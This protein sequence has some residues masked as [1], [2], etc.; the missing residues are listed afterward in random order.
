M[1][2]RSLLLPGAL[3]LLAMALAVILTLGRCSDSSLAPASPDSHSGV[4][5][6][7]LQWRAGSSQRY[8]LVVESS[9]LMTM[10]G[11]H[12]GQT[13][14]LR[15][16][17]DL[18]YH[19]LQVDAAGVIAGMR[20]T[21]IDMSI[22]GAGDADVNRSLTSPFRVH[23]ADN[24][25]PL[26]FEFPAEL[27]AGH[28]EVLENIVRMFQAVILA[29]SGWEVEESNAS[30]RYQA[31]Y[32]TTS[33]Y[34]LEKHKQR[35]L[36]TDAD[37]SVPEV[38]SAESIRIE[39]S[40]DWLT[41]MIVDE[42]ITTREPGSA[43]VEVRNHASI[44]LQSKQAKI[45]AQ[46][47]G[48]P[49]ADTGEASA[50]N[51]TIVPLPL[52]EAERR[53]ADEIAI[54]ET[55]GEGRSIVIHRL[56]DLLLANEQLPEVL[57]DTMRTRELTDRT[58]ADIYLAFEL[59]GTPA[60]QASLTTVVLDAGWPP[61]DAMRAIVALGGMANP[62]ADTLSTLWDMAHTDLTETERR[63]LPGTAALAIGSLGN[64]LRTA[65]NSD[66]LSLRTDLVASATSA[67]KPQAKTVFLYA[68]ANTADPDPALRRDI[69]PFLDDPSPRVRSA[70]ARSLGRLGTDE[71]AKELLQSAVQ[72]TNN[73]VRASLAEALASW[74]EP[75]PE[76]IQW[77]RAAIGG[78]SDEKA[79]YNMAVL[80]GNNMES[81]P[82]NRIL[83]EA[84]LETEQSR[85]I[86]QRVADMLY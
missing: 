82:E 75:T 33:P 61:Q 8:T 11:S 4:S 54:L 49:A 65:E 13:M 15:I 26:N 18:Q 69:L 50:A 46:D 60:A 22:D 64:T 7:Q 59:A 77:A 9:F 56:R 25:L 43:L 53:L 16:K 14:D 3:A 38:S 52:P 45:A 62:T 66:Y 31:I 74:K 86:R 57:L 6:I 37:T 58:R 73:E 41:A 51:P 2:L 84:L 30:G 70:A 63:D 40:H 21:S 83:L 19:T 28:R 23:F 29:G 39:S 76:A 72:E 68:L 5:P 80:L 20:F 10:P 78:E 81:F 44:E 35:Y 32:A 24:G 67:S 36:G 71:V 79:R 34:T 48:F 85:R 12:A 27:V 55:A 42:T 47:W 1:H 17:G